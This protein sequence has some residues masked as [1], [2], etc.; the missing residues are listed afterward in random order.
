MISGGPQSPAPRTKWAF[1]I[2]AAAAAVVILYWIRDVIFVT[3]FGVLLGILVSYMADAGARWLRIPRTAA[4]IASTLVVCA[5]A[6]G[7]LALIAVPIVDQ[8]AKFADA[9]PQYIEKAERYVA[10]LR[11]A[12]PGLSRYIPE[13][14]GIHAGAQE[15]SKVAW[16]AVSVV[17]GGVGALVT[18]VGVVFIALFCALDP[19]RYVRGIADLWPGPNAPQLWLMVRIGRALRSWMIAMGIDILVAAVLRTVALWLVGIDY[20]LVFG[21]VGAFFQIVPYFGPLL[22]FV[23]PFLFAL[24]LSPHTAVVVTVIYLVIQLFDSYILYPYLMDA[25]VKVPPV[26]VLVAIMALGSAFGFWGTV[27]SMPILTVVYVLVN[28]VWLRPKELEA[29]T[30]EPPLIVTPDEH[31]G[32]RPAPEPA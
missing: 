4:V 12:H 11:A 2:A 24:T 20:F 23:P 25:Q 21:V 16:T 28:Q 15:A 17:A 3:F 9:L 6:A 26:L 18:L 30:E 5:V 10:Q 1:T 8:V 22:A 14:G 27:L 7:L 31:G 32:A 19:D 13:G 29:E